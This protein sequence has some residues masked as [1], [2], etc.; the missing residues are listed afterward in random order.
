MDQEM[1]LCQIGSRL[2]RKNMLAGCDGNLSFRR[3]DGTIVI[4]PSAVP[5]GFLDPSMLLVVDGEGH[6][7]SGDGKPSSEMKLHLEAYRRRPDVG[8]VIHAHPPVATAVTVAG[9]SFPSTIV[10]EG[11]DVLGP[12]GI[13]PYH[14]PSTDQL[15]QECGAMLETHDVILLS[16]HGAAAVGRDLA[17]AFYRMET[18]EMTAAIYR[19]AL[20]FSTASGRKG[21]LSLLPYISNKK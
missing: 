14:S 9:I 8:A 16:N 7:L 5:K 21:E 19:D 10:T 15:A 2:Y 12:V 13:V 6:I 11:R 18:L 3:S 17:E 1:L 4:T 20:L